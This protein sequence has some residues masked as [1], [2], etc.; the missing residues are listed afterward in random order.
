MRHGGDGEIQHRVRDLSR[1]HRAGHDASDA[2]Q[3]VGR[4]Q[5]VVD[6]DLDGPRLEKSGERLA[7]DG[8]ER[9][10]QALPVRAN[11]IDE[12]GAKPVQARSR[13]QN[14]P[15][16]HVMQRRARRVQN[17]TDRPARA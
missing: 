3:S 9:Q 17:E 7:Q 2:R 4:L 11:E 8:D 5:H 12:H 1:R 6:D 16:E 15:A 13:R 10:R 14:H